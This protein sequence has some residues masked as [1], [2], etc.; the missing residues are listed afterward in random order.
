MRIDMV[1][2]R[3][4]IAKLLST[5]NSGRFVMGMKGNSPKAYAIKWCLFEYN[6]ILCSSNFGK[7]KN[8]KEDFRILLKF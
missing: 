6:D 8:M 5:P 7:V 1:I 2:T 4:M 3:K